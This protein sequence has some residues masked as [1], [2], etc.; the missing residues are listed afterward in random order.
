MV[1]V[2]FVFSLCLCPN[3]EPCASKKHTAAKLF[4]D[5]EWLHIYNQSGRFSICVVYVMIKMFYKSVNLDIS[6]L[7]IENI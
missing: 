1:V 6:L 7:S 4:T 5:A 3:L 2:G